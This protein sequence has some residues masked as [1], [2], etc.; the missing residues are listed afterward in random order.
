MRPSHSGCIQMVWGVKS[1][2]DGARGFGGSPA[3]RSRRIQAQRSIRGNGKPQRQHQGV[4]L[5]RSPVDQL[6]APAL[7]LGAVA[8]A[9]AL[10]TIARTIF[11]VAGYMV[12]LALI[13]AA[14]APF[15]AG[16]STA[17][18]VGP[19]TPAKSPRPF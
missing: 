6:D 2:P 8:A 4:V 1:G 12:I 15:Q 10:M 3:A 5:T 16:D 11:V 17:A 7:S 19:R 14:C 9:S 13:T 18:V